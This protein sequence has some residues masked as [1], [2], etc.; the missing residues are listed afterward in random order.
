MINNKIYIKNSGSSKNYFSKELNSSIS[1]DKILNYG[2]LINCYSNSQ[3]IN[4]LSFVCSEK[5]L[6]LIK[7][8]DKLIDA[9]YQVKLYDYYEVIVI[10]IVSKI[11]QGSYIYINSPPNLKDSKNMMTTFEAATK[12]IADEV[13]IDRT[14]HAG[15]LS[16]SDDFVSLEERDQKL[17]ECDL[18]LNNPNVNIDDF[19]EDIKKSEPVKVSF[20]DKKRLGVDKDV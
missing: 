17:L 18:E 4:N 13:T 15:R 14:V 7:N 19:F 8:N 10:Y 1:K 2:F 11:P 3:L 9:K 5:E 12:Q 16:K 6:L 20:V